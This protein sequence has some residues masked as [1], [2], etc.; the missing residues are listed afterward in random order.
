MRD[1]YPSGT[2]YTGHGIVVEHSQDCLISC[3][4]T[5]SLHRGIT[6]LGV[7]TGTQ[8]RLNWMNKHCSGITLQENAVLND[9]YYAGSS[10]RTSNSNRWRE[11]DVMVG[12]TESKTDSLDFYQDPNTYGGYTASPN[13]ANDFKLLN[14]DCTVIAGNCTTT[15]D[16][17]C[18]PGL[19]HV[20]VEIDC[21]DPGEH[22]NLATDFGTRFARN[23]D[24]VISGLDSFMYVKW[25]DTL[26][27]TGRQYVVRS[28]FEHPGLL[29]GN[30][31]LQTFMTNQAGTNLEKLVRVDTLIAAGDFSGA[32]TL[33]DSI[34]ATFDVEQF[35]KDV[36][37]VY[38]ENRRLGR[39][40]LTTA[41][42][43][44]LLNVANKC[45]QKFGTAV[46]QARAMLAA[47]TDDYRFFSNDCYVGG[48]RFGADASGA[49]DD[50]AGALRVYPNPNSGK[51][52]ADFFAKEAGTA[53]LKVVD[54]KGAVVWQADRP[55]AAGANHL[56]LETDLAPGVYALEVAQGAGRWQLK[57]V[58]H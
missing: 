13:Y 50:R 10:G 15:T 51:F 58:V 55:V 21:E 24:F 7:C 20:S 14:F 56:E 41:Q 42:D 5:D 4:L 30:A 1:Y 35:H 45:P 39:D 43:A 17:F 36:N 18:K 3:N 27:W 49:T 54:A 9:Q 40:T 16:T 57:I 31:H 47:P 44:A 22:L 38:L 8:L 32:E 46:Y 29:V 37:A 2:T 28:V 25:V 26:G 12:V 52:A 34:I 23:T 19:H 33:N 53:K 48:F 11:C 6:V